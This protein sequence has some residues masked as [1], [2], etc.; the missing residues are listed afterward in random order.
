MPD[1]PVLGII[2]TPI[3]L[4]AICFEWWAVRRGRIAGRYCARDTATSLTMCAGNIA[5]NSAM[6][7]LSFW[8]LATAVD[9]RPAPLEVTALTIGTGLLVHDLLYY[10]KHRIGHRARWFWAEHVT[11][12]SSQHYNLTTALRQP[13]TGP[14]TGLVLIGGPMVLMG[15]PVS[16][17]LGTAAVHLA[18]QFWIHT[19]AI[20]RL[21]GWLEAVI[22]T[23][24]HHRVHHATNP[25]YLDS[26]YGGMLIIW[27]RLFGTFVREDEEETTRYGIVPPLKSHN[28]V[29][30]AYHGFAGLFS[31]F[32]RD[33][34]RPDRWVRRAINPPGWS[35][36]GDHHRSEEIRAD[37]LSRQS[38]GD[39]A[40]IVEDS[41]PDVLAIAAE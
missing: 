9:V 8:V 31:D 4:A 30:V 13:W 17:V 33:G 41:A 27:D 15:F 3:V 2:A 23:P 34:I 36:Q 25:Q 35:P 12:H 39:A 5:I 26:N 10:W 6:A 28:P 16:I 37:W 1:L 32:R 38:A 20:G 14:M 24:S 22:V 19:E 11:H 40:D 29:I 21:P 7:F 18:Y